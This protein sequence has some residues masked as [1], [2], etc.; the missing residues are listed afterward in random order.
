MGVLFLH[1]L[2]D[3]R[4]MWKIDFRCVDIA[5]MIIHANIKVLM[6]EA[7][8]PIEERMFQEENASGK[9]E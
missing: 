2:V 9:S 1:S 6:I 3:W 7:F 5:S 8:L 4:L